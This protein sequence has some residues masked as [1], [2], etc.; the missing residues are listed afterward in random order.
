MT[1]KLK[2]AV[3]YGDVLEH[4]V[5]HLSIVVVVVA[6][7]VDIVPVEAY[8]RPGRMLAH[9]THDSVS[10][11]LGAHSTRQVAAQ[12]RSQRVQTPQR[13]VTR[14]AGASRQPHMVGRSHAVARMQGPI[15]PAHL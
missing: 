11:R 14:R 8:T 1:L 12:E 7:V 2:L 6:V 5:L 13:R 3:L 4:N 10:A 15:E 9:S